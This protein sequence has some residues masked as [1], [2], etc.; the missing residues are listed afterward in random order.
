M[1]RAAA[2][3]ALVVTLLGGLSGCGSLWA[4]RVITLRY[5]AD[6]VLAPLG[7]EVTADAGEV[8]VAGAVQHDWQRERALAL[9][10]RGP[11]VEAAYFVDLDRP[12]RPVT[13]ERFRAEPAR[14]WGAAI[15]AVSV[16]GWRLQDETAE[17]SLATVPRRVQGTWISLGIA[18]ETRLFL[19]LHPRGESVTVIATVQRGDAADLAWCL[20]EERRVVR[21]IGETLKAEGGTAQP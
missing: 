20:D 16:T 14:V 17:R 4:E 3:L 18:T 11:G 15:A 19:Q 8:F 5:Q 10:R 2:V 6:P 7:L 1:G 13:F 21:A 9:A 12:D